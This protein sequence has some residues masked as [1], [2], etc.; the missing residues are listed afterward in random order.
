[1]KKNTKLIVLLLAGLLA[2]GGLAQARKLPEGAYI[3][4]AKIHILSGEMERYQLA[5]YMLDSLF[6]NYG[7]HAE[8]L[9]LMNQ[10]MV[11]VLEKTPDITE[12]EKIIQR[13]VAYDDSLKMCCNNKDI[14]SKYKKG[15]D[16]FV[17]KADSTIV[18][19]WREFY[20]L[21]VG[22]L[23]RLKQTVKDLSTATDSTEIAFFEK[24]RDALIDTT[25]KAMDIAIQLDPTDF[26]TYVGISTVYEENRNFD[27][28]NAWLERGAQY[29][30][31]PNSVNLQIAYNFIKA[32][33]Y[34]K[35]APPLKKYCDEAMTDTTNM[36]NLGVCYNACEQYD[37]AL[38]VYRDMLAFSPSEMEALMA[39]GTFFNQQARYANDSAT[40]Y[41]DKEDA[42]AADHWMG[43]RSRI[44]DSSLYYFGHAFAA[45]DTVL[46]VAE[47]Y[48]MI[49]YVQGQYDKSI[50]AYTK[51]VQID[52]TLTDLWLSLGDSYVQT[53]QFSKAIHP[54]EMVVLQDP[55]NREMLERLVDL[56]KEN[57]QTKK[58]KETQARLDKLK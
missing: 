43:E 49:A 29:A 39:V 35:A 57:K 23:D 51:A 10:M 12:K 30:E 47:Q 15:C 45:H 33:D 54:Y 37:E 44:L 5:E 38:Q 19:Y 16:D 36:I 11:D 8:A 7:P 42:K 58:A 26:R 20:N 55:N 9:F 3:K 31:H 53:Q 48:G 56:Y 21:G 1:M 14:K 34:C 41:R 52:S 17:A 32:R 4:S 18:K 24:K 50:E 25:I 6:L 22:S 2:F 28:A 46:N 13:L 27:S 40:V